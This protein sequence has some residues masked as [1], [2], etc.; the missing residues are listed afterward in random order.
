MIDSRWLLFLLAWALAA[1]VQLV[2]YLVQR[3]TGDA[4]AVDAGWAASLAAIA[5]LYGLL[6]DGDATMRALVAVTAGLEN[7]RLAV[8]VSR[9][10]GAG[11]DRRYRELRARWRARGIEQRRFLVFFQAQALLAAILSLPLLLAAFD[12]GIGALAWVGAALWLVAASLEW[13]ADAQLRRFTREPANDGRTMR[14]GLWRYSRHPN[15]FFQWLTWVAYAL[16]ALAAPYGWIGLVSPAIMLM[17]ILFVTGVPP[18]EESSLRS[19]GDEYR[20]YQRATSVFVPWF[21]KGQG[22]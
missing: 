20:S 12:D 2:L 3:R 10:I 5:V 9:R 19:R 16:I 17:L 4:T 13:V 6:A 21:P 22:A 8:H 15:Y 14:S 11:E 7:L 1:A 18:A